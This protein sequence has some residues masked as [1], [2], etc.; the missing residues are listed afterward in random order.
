[1]KPH[2]LTLLSGHHGPTILLNGHRIAGPKPWNGG[3]VMREWEIPA[4][5]VEKALEKEEEK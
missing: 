2:T 1:M 3:T 4:E 5:V